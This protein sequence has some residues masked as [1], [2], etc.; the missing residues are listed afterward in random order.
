MRERT[1]RVMGE[2]LRLMEDGAGPPLLFLHGAGG[3]N[4]NPLL[5]NLAEKFRVI[6]PQHP[7]FGGDLPDWML[8]MGDL[9][10][11]Y[12]DVLAALD[13]PPVHLVGHSLGGWL[14]AEM[15]IRD[16]ASLATLSLLA[17]AGV[18]VPEAP[19]GDIFLWTPEENARNQFHDQKLAEAR[20]RALPQADL[21]A[22]LRNRAAAARL[23]WSPRLHNPQL[24]VW[25]HRIHLPT[26][27]LWGAEDKIIPAACKRIYQREIPHAELVLLA[28]SGHSL[29]G[30]RP[31]ETAA[32]LADFIGRAQA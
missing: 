3:A 12:L 14:A 16:Q 22:T 21:D 11:F 25:L 13:L 6:A 32:A 4:W 15:A 17:P 1:I 29:H 5:K 28:E 30:E 10:F 9:A 18:A 26:L 24:P 23:A 19:F 27:L 2:D 7:G 20:I 31:A 8:G